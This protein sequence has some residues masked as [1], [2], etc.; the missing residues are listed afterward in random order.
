VWIDRKGTV[1]REHEGFAL[2]ERAGIEQG[3][4]DLIQGR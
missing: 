2:S 4:A 1:V 3:I